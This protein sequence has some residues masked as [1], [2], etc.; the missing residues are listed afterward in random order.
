MTATDIAQIPM[1]SELAATLARGAEFAGATGASDVSLEHLLAALCDDPDAAAVLEASNISGERI[2]ADVISR[3]LGAAQ[4]AQQPQDSLGVSVEVRRILEAAS[5]A[6]RGSRRR[7]INGAIVLAASVGDARSAAAEILEAHG[8]TFENAIRALQSALAP[9]REVLPAPQPPVTDDVLARARERVQSRS[10]PSLR[11]I[12]KDM[13]RPAP[14]APPVAM[15]A[16]PPPEPPVP[17]PPFPQAPSFEVKPEASV[18]LPEI[19]SAPDLANEPVGPPPRAAYPRTE[20][21]RSEPQRPY[22]Q[23]PVAAP[24]TGGGPEV[25]RRTEPSFGPPGAAPRPGELSGAGAPGATPG[26]PQFPNE[27]SLSPPSR[28]PQQAGPG[29]GLRQE[30]NP[31]PDAGADPRLPGQIFADLP[32]RPQ[33]SRIQPPPIPSAG[34]APGLGGPPLAGR[35]R[36]PGNPGPTLA[37]PPNQPGS[38]QF[39]PPGP[40]LSPNAPMG[41]PMAPPGRP[42]AGQDPAFRPGA[43]IGGP[44]RPPAQAQAPRRTAKRNKGADVETGQLAENI[45]RSMRVGKTVR[46]E[47]RIAK[48]SVKALTEGLEGTGQVWQHPIAATKAMSVRVRAPDGGFFIESASPETQWIESNLGYASDDFASW[49]FLITPQSR[50]WSDLQIIV[51]ARTIGAD[52]VAAETALPDQIVEVKVRTNLARTFV[53]L[54]SWT[55]AAVVGGALATFGETGMTIATAL[56]KKFGH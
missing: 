50:G 2:K 26:P 6:A 45:P 27:P 37:P 3:V 31:F 15:P 7:D 46:A 36:G 53:R 5:A 4:S 11:D 41:A 10:A 30:A 14:M 28:S 39:G 52:G 12:M 20:L 42:N 55:V 54:F 22:E 21:P 34:P 32:P 48:A 9:P 18:P 44:A 25:Q 17:Q 33:P 40:S 16:A 51:S 24:Q 8:L 49:R 1:S 19:V 56:M 13:P 43:P 29:G 35:A 47:I 23:A 38:S